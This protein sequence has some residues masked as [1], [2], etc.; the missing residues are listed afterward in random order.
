MAR[1]EDASFPTAGAVGVNNRWD[2][3]I[4]I[5][6]PGGRLVLFALTGVNGDRLSQA[7]L[8]QKECDLRRVWGRVE[9]ESD[10][11]LLL[12]SRQALRF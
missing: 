1:I 7:R 9:I 5:D 6:G 12:A 4:G 3:P 2:F 11:G 8:L 10:H